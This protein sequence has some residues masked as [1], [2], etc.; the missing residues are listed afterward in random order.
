MFILRSS[1]LRSR[2][3]SIL[4][5]SMLRSRS[6]SQGLRTLSESQIR[7]IPRSVLDSSPPVYCV[8]MSSFRCVR[9]SCVRSSWFHCVR[10]RID[11][12]TGN[13]DSSESLVYGSLLTSEVLVFRL[14]HHVG[15]HIKNSGENAR[16]PEF[17]ALETS[18]IGRRLRINFGR[19]LIKTTHEVIK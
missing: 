4:R 17:G 15:R 7:S 6:T 14:F 5:S 9:A 10:A 16:F 19:T 2:T 8:R 1:T 11:C 12:H 18:P 13:S 3:T